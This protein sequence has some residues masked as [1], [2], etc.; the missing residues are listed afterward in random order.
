[1][2]SEFDFNGNVESG[3]PSKFSLTYFIAS[4]IE[5]YNY[6]Y[7]LLKIRKKFLKINILMFYV[8]II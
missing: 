2:N 4:L 8:R 7:F 1:M 5:T 6:H 3:P